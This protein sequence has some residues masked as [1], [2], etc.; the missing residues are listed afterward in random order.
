M[1]LKWDNETPDDFVFALK[2]PREITH[3]HKLE[4]EKSKSVMNSFFS[5]L[6][7]LKRKIKVLVLQLPPS[8]DFDTAKLRLEILLDHFPHYCRYAIE[9]RNESWFFSESIDFMKQNNLCL[10]WNEVPMVENPAPIT[11]DFVYSRLIGDRN[12]PENAYDRKM[13]DQTPILQK[14]AN[15][16][17]SLQKNKELKFAYA[18]LN[19][20]LEGFAPSS[21]NSLR[22]LMGYEEV[23][24]R[25]QRQKTVFD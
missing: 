1:A 3:D 7:P 24:F 18:V 23:K 5:G 17:I 15:R 16:L 6:E 12:L 25:D 22:S 9:G 4:Y 21:A 13:R 2:F 14:W 11:T 20:H 8:L 10:V 19:N